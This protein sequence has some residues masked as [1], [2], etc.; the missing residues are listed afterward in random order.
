MAL[1]LRS[2]LL[3]SALVA[4]VAGSAMAEDAAS[5]ADPAS[6]LRGSLPAGSGYG[7]TTVA[8]PATTGTPGTPGT[9][10]EAGETDETAGEAVPADALADAGEEDP[11]EPLGIRSGGMVYLPK[12]ELRA[13]W[14]NNGERTRGGG[15]ARYLEIA[16][17]LVGKSDWS[18][19]SLEL[20]LRG[21]Y[22]DYVGGD[23]E[24][25]PSLSALAKGRL[26]LRETTA[27]ALSAGYDL[28]REEAFDPDVAGV[29]DRPLIHGLSG[30]IGLAEEVGSFE[31]KP[32][33]S[34]ARTIYE[35]DT[36]GASRNST[37][38]EGGLRLTH[39]GG[40]LHPFVEGLALRR[41]Y[42]D[43]V[44]G[45]G[46][47][48]AAL[49]GELRGGL[50]FDY[51]EILTGEVA[52]GYRREK[53]KEPSLADLEG[54]TLAGD[55]TWT[56]SALT[57]VTVD[58]RTDFNPSTVLGASGS[59][60]HQADIRLSHAL[61]R[62]VVVDLG[63]ALGREAY[64]GLDRTDTTLEA[65]AGATYKINRTAAVT[66]RARHERFATTVP[67]E[68]YTANSFEVGLTLQR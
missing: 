67:G 52:V 66:A 58:A 48:R 21:T 34:V 45:N 44:D 12:V 51:D 9:E 8:D 24:A 37:L 46:Q 59:V 27:I 38:L 62:N 33:A 43:E 29:V 17:E 30:S 28:T 14:T 23:I 5:G 3:G 57:K 41:L 42:D 1:S 2:A 61:R 63:L 10:A 25:E 4:A 16:P 36:S 40:T 20:S 53:L 60:R 31:V 50:E 18:R 54:W 64:T 39:L 68:D 13:G 7:T 26:D 55:V 32:L 65:S 22:R 47:R 15:D 6:G 19:H 35:R 11:Y 56:V 49:G